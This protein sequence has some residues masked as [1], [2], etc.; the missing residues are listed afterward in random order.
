MVKE[1]QIKSVLNKT[2]KR[3]PW[4]LDDYTLNLYSSCAFNCLYCYIRGSKYGENLAH[5]LSVKVNALEILEKQLA[6]RA[7]KGQYGFIVL[8]SATDPYLHI[9]KEYRL[10]RQAL[11]IIRNYRFPVH[12]I[13]K[14]DLVLR[15]FD[16]L[17]EIDQ[18]AIVPND[19][20]LHSGTILS[21]SFSTLDDEQAKLFESG[22]PLPSKRLKALESAIENKLR[23]GVSLMPLLPFISD[24]T[25]ALT[26]FFR[27]FS[28]L[29]ARYV[30][31]A[32][33]TLFGSDKADSKTLVLEII[34]RHYPELLSKYEKWFA[35]S[36][37]MPSF[38]RKAFA[39]KMKELSE[40]YNLPNRIYD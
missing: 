25:A 16:L 17:Q 35:H 24:T 21:F 7:K 13:T 9:E 2:K 18:T 20:P 31:P 33:L 40:E 27:S 19:V 26:H 11:E 30:L 15:D 4:F 8:S 10:T 12:I 14:S 32:T 36:S 6:L 37:Q 22:A 39:E 29:Q 38:Y 28:T 5:S 23:A 3:D 1:I 34:K